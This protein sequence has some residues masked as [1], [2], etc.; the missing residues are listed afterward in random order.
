MLENRAIITGIFKVGC[1]SLFFLW[2]TAGASAQLGVRVDP[3]PIT[4]A[5]N[6]S[7]NVINNQVSRG[8][9]QM[10]SSVN[11]GLGQ[12]SS[13]INRGLNGLNSYSYYPLVQVRYPSYRTTYRPTS[14]ANRA[15]SAARSTYYSP[16]TLTSPTVQQ[17]EPIRLT[18]EQLAALQEHQAA[19]AKSQAGLGIMPADTLTRLSEMQAGLQN[20][21]QQA[22]FD[23]PI[24][25]II[26]W[27]YEGASGSAR[28]VSESRFGT[29]YCRTFEQSLT[30]EGNKQ[31][32]SASACRRS[33]GQWALSAY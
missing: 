25:E 20:A 3:A 7:L 28:A 12:V 24:G 17:S 29:L 1:I 22:A 8:L 31:T 2:L 4:G 13:S 33:N 11:R 18:E 23:A 15:S 10:S 16:N 14:L 30:H 32:A 21:A 9:T 19:L 5:V 27:S 6:Q 26:E